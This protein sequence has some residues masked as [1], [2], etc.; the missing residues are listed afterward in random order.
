[1]ISAMRSRFAGVFHAGS[2][3]S[4]GCSVGSQPRLSTSACLINDGMAEKS[5]TDMTKEQGTDENDA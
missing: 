3:T 1:M 2:V 4:I 5:F